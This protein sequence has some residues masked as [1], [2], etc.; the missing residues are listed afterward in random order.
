MLGN[1]SMEKFVW[2]SNRK[3]TM[4]FSW[5]LSEWYCW[6]TLTTV[7]HYRVHG[8]SVV[9]RMGGEN[10]A[11]AQNTY[12]VGWFRGRELNFVFGLQLSFS[13]VVCNL[14]L[15]F[16]TEGLQVTRNHSHYKT[17]SRAGNTSHISN[18]G[19]ICPPPFQI[20]RKLAILVNLWYGRADQIS[21]ASVHHVTIMMLN[22]YIVLKSC[23]KSQLNLLHC[24]RNR[25]KWKETKRT[26]NRKS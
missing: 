24:V 23:R 26:T 13:R 20:S 22:I 14:C 5:S 7:W 21:P 19:D 10:L 17:S 3:W 12:A 1:N 2:R 16:P 11:V 25:K 4:G 8:E 18:L 6:L 9:F 15:S